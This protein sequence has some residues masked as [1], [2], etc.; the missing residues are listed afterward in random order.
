M[1]SAPF[2]TGMGRLADLSKQKPI[3]LLQPYILTVS[4]LEPRAIFLC[5]AGDSSSSSGKE[6]L[7]APPEVA[8]VEFGVGGTFGALLGL[9]QLETTV[10]EMNL[11]FS[12]ARNFSN[13]DSRARCNS[14]YSP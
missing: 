4:L 3:S 10:G 1:F 5:L 14:A 8:L 7:L 6:G 12:I 11:F 13:P 2:G 9:F